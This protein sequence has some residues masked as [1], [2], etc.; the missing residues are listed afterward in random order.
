MTENKAMK[1]VWTPSW[2]ELDQTIAVGMEGKFWFFQDKPSNDSADKALDEVELVFFNQLDSDSNSEVRFA[3]V[4]EIV[5]DILGPL[6]RVDTDGL[7]Y[8]FAL[9]NGE[10]VVVNAEEEPGQTY[11]DGCEVEN[12]TVLVTLKEVSDPISDV[13]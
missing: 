11:D 10:E 9:A 12:W 3:H 6:Q 8:V 1:A 2:Y 5:H 13:V 7:D 4:E